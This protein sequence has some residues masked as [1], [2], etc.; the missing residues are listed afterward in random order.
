MA[1]H[2]LTIQLS[3]D[4]Y[5][6]LQARAEQSGRDLNA[7]ITHLLE[8]AI[9]G[10]RTLSTAAF[11][12][13]LELLTDAELLHA[14]AVQ[15]RPDEEARMQQLLDKQQRTGLTVLE[16]DSLLPLATHFERIMLT[17]ARAAALLKQRGHDVATLI[18]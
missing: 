16:N 4:I 12:D 1:G 13:Q 5:H 14:A 15:S 17:R 3:D 10:D 6:R 8:I 7:E 2:P 18:D 11:L 9:A